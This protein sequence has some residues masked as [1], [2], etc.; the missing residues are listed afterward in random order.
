MKIEVL[1]KNHQYEEFDSSTFVSQ[2]IFP[3]GNILTNWVLHLDQIETKGIILAA[4]CY[5]KNGCSD[6]TVI[7][8]TAIPITRRN[9]GYAMLLVSADELAQLVWLKKDG[10][11]ILWRE[12][13]DLINGERFFAMEQLCYSDSGVIS[14]NK[15]A[16]SIFDYL[17]NAHPDKD[18]ENIAT[19]MG[20][21]L[22]A[23]ER[24]R[25]QELAQADE[26]LLTIE[27]DYNP[28]FDGFIEYYE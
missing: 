6:T 5:N 3:Q 19:S 8:E 1:Y 28:D 4:H 14:I 7:G 25:D 2:D 17:K 12:G 9:I 18:D 20:Y 23:L 22:P 21:T 24:I 11:K 26:A 27:D 13:D 10:E 15:R 16:L